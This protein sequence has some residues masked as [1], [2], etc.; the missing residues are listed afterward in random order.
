M[1]RRAESPHPTPRSLLTT[2]PQVQRGFKAAKFRSFR[3]FRILD[4]FCLSLKKTTQVPSQ[5]VPD[6]RSARCCQQLGLS[7]PCD[8][9]F[10]LCVRPSELRATSC[11]ILPSFPGTSRSACQPWSGC[12]CSAPHPQADPHPQAE[13]A[14]HPQTQQAGAIT[15]GR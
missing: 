4:R 10:S 14:G 8:R 5:H 2:P 15:C 9:L 11:R 13:Q 12:A 1:V 3:L 6:N 7:L